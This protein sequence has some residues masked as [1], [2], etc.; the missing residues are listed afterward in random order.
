MT[1]I[2]KEPFGLLRGKAVDCY[3]IAFEGQLDI[4]ICTYGGIITALRVPDRQGQMADVVLG[5]DRLE[6]Y[7]QQGDYFGAIVGRYG[8]RI[9]GGSFVLD[10]EPIELACNNEGN[11]LHGGECGF[12]RQLW[13][14]LDISETDSEVMLVL[15][16]V[17]AD[18]DGG[19]PGTLSTQVRYRVTADSV[20][21]EYRASTDRT[22]VVN[23]TQHSYFNL[24]AAGDILRHS[25]Q[26]DAEHFLPVDETMIPT[27]ELRSVADTAFDFRQRQAIGPA[28]AAED[29]QLTLA[30]GFDHCWVLPENEAGL[31]RE[32]ARLSEPTSGRSLRVLTTEPGL[33]FYCGNFL[34]AGHRG[35]G[36]RDYGHR[37]GLCLETQH[38]PNS[39][40]EPSFPS[41]TL[42]PGQSYRSETVFQFTL[43]D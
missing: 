11:H 15:G 12:D 34:N 9:K 27:G 25:L 20:A 5:Y 17:S 1:R 14:P 29:A 26:L 37:S 7:C 41:T 10:G 39:P 6:D 32:V 19:Y 16:L 35:K 43:E 21:V 24:A 8:N 36:G 22:T 3:R 28:L 18:G 30:G 31:L 2:S 13:Q 33:Q 4:C 42:R 38:F 23:L 40:N